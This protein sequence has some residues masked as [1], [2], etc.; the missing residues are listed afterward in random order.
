M[1]KRIIAYSVQVTILAACFYYIFSDVDFDSLLT[2]FLQYSLF[3]VLTVLAVT[4]PIYALMGLRLS[5]LSQGLITIW[6]GICGTWLA[7]GMNNVLPARL[8]EVGKA[9][10]FQ[11]KTELDL[12]MAM[13]LIFMER[14]LDVN[15][16]ALVLIAS[17]TTIGLGLM[18]LPFIG[19]VAIGWIILLVLIKR[20]PDT[21]AALHFIPWEKLR[22]FGCELT[23]ALKHCLAGNNILK[24]ILSTVSIWLINF[25]YIMLI[26]L[27]LMQLDLSFAQ[28]LGVFV[29]VNVG[30]SIPGMPGGLGV[31][32]GGIVAILSWSGIPKTEAL[33]LALT[34][35][36]FNFLPPTLLGMMVLVSSGLKVGSLQNKLGEK[37]FAHDDNNSCSR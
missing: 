31:M 10:F 9:V 22:H 3:H 23:I 5:Q 12:P 20:L 37:S 26:P 14:F 33:A 17:T 25:L 15:I 16:V 21:G 4:I 18:G 30:L 6:L 36:A 11:R 24:P 34:I 35:R 29:A 32:E 8:G 19:A 27:H 1:G 28:V 2:T 7:V 13:G